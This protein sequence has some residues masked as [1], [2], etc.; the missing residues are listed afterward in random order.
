MQP[1]L[2]N[3]QFRH[4]GRN[5]LTLC[6]C[7]SCQ[8]QDP[9]KQGMRIRNWEAD[10]HRRQSALRETAVYSRGRGRGRISTPSHPPRHPVLP[11]VLKRVWAGSG[12]LG[13]C[14]EDPATKRLRLGLSNE[15][16]QDPTSMNIDFKDHGDII[17][18]IGGAI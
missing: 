4:R 8:D 13:T 6:T 17:C 14:I 9:H 11:L 10:R 2:F 3:P 1:F 18:W 7:P 5:N 15:G 16:L 12:S